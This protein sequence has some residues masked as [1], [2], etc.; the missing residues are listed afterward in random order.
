MRLIGLNVK[1][2]FLKVCYGTN[3]YIVGMLLRLSSIKYSKWQTEPIMRF[4]IDKFSQK[5][6]SQTHWME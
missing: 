6:N 4:D 3:Y 1:I 2:P 5:S